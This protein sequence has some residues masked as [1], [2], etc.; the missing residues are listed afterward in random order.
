[1]RR[2][3]PKRVIRRLFIEQ[4]E[5]RVFGLVPYISVRYRGVVEQS[6]VPCTFCGQIPKSGGMYDYQ[7]RVL[8]AHETARLCK[9]NPACEYLEAVSDRKLMDLR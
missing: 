2:V 6:V 9:D 4:N 1:M 3:V 5:A 7:V 8:A